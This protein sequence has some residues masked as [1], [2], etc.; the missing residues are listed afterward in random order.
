[1]ATLT[2]I[3]DEARRL[4]GKQTIGIAQVGPLVYISPGDGRTITVKGDMTLP[5]ADFSRQALQP[6]LKEATHASS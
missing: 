6:A 4:L 1:V 2:E 5:L 3:A